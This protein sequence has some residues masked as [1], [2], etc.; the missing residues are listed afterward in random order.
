MAAVICTLLCLLIGGAAWAQSGSQVLAEVGVVG[1]NSQG[2]GV[3]R[4]EFD[5][6]TGEYTDWVPPAALRDF[7]GFSISPRGTALV[8]DGYFLREFNIAGVPKTDRGFP[9]D[10][11]STSLEFNR[12]KNNGQPSFQTLDECAAF[13][14]MNDGSL[15]IAGEAQGGGFVIIKAVYDGTWTATLA[16]DGTPPSISDMD[17]DEFEDA[18]SRKGAG[19]W[20]VG[21]RK[22]VLW[23]PTSPADSGDFDVVTTLNG[24]RIDSVTPG[25]AN[26]VFVV[27]DSGEILS[28]NASTG[29]TTAEPD[30]ILDSA[31]SCG[32]ED[33]K[34]RQ[35]YSLRFDPTGDGLLYAGNRGCGN[36]TLFAINQADGSLEKFTDPLV[37]ANPFELDESVATST[38]DSFL[39][40]TLDY[41]AGQGGDFTEGCDDP[42]VLGDPESGCQ[43]GAVENQAIMFDVKVA[44]GVNFDTTYRMFQFVD[45]VDCRHSGDRPC[46]ILNCPAAADPMAAPAPGN[47]P[48]PTWDPTLDPANMI[49]NSNNPPDTGVPE[50]Q[51][52]DLTQ[53]LLEADETGVF[54]TLAFGDETPPVMAIP[55]Y[56]RG[57]ATY[58]DLNGD[59]VDN[60]YKFVSFFAV[61]DAIFQKTF[62]VDYRINLFR[63]GDSDDECFIPPLQS[64]IAAVNETA[65]LIV[66]NS[67]DGFGTVYR[68]AVQEDRGGVIGNSFCNGGASRAR[69]SANTI[70]LEFHEDDN[71]FLYIEQTTR[72]AEELEDVRRDL[73]C[74]PFPNPAGGPDLGP[75]LD[76][77][78]YCLLIADEVEQVQLKL[79]TCTS[80]QEYPI[81]GNSQENCNAFFTKILNLRNVTAP[82]PWPP[83]TE[84]N[85]D[86]LRPNYEGEFLARI[87]ALEFFV[88]SYLLNSVPEDGIGA[89]PGP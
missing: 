32:Q 44:Q 8:L 72:M 38:M 7:R 26:R 56:M 55:A 41:Q 3:V 29:A 79:N 12:P 27:L 24:K 20:A 46:P 87:D 52:L 14:V 45:L 59:P 21:D 63:P 60:G 34:F 17:G 19:Y 39:V 25:D 4:P 58:P 40:E 18:D 74:S 57:E 28:V 2:D 1:E 61:T 54:E 37:A 15:R 84:A 31:V 22:K 5:S 86:L 35:R 53:L 33:R 80:A 49:C 6:T 64:T 65:N 68:D 67:G 43:Y 83:V 71:E 42:L 76:D 50:E 82:A 16:A 30:A 78:A 23:F 75:L 70:G 77:E 81:Q 88:E 85:I 73:L 36:I 48:G 10:C 66:Y 89:P 11:T 9:V 13:T 69:W 51:V 47:P 62:F